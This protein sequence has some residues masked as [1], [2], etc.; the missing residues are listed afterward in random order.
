MIHGENLIVAVGGTPLAASKSCNVSKSQSFIEVAA[1][2]AG[3]WESFVPQKL[4]WKITADCLM[5]TMEAYKT[6]DAA[7]KAGTALTIRFYDTEYNEN[8]TG[9]AYIENLDLTAS[10]GSLAKM[11]VSLK[12]SGPLS[13]YSGVEISLTTMSETDD[14]Y[15]AYYSATGYF[16]P[17]NDG[18]PYSKL[19]SMTLAK[20][21]RVRINPSTG[22][23][24]WVRQEADQYIIDDFQ[25]EVT[26]ER[27]D[28]DDCTSSI[29]YVMLDAGTYTLVL[30]TDD[31]DRFDPSIKNMS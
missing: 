6:L 28:Y 15:Y 17:D 30:T 24:I 12:G 3:R 20:R 9:T 11:S 14:F 8:E 21:S 10:K 31:Y 18:H 16:Y 26:I 19:C 27:E 22:F 1:P 13:E 23:I 29:K 7:W 2:T 5:G 4:G 25:R